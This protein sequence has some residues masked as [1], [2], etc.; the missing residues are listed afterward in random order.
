MIFTNGARCQSAKLIRFKSATQRFPTYFTLYTLYTL[1]AVVFDFVRPLLY[2]AKSNSEYG[3]LEFE[4][5]FV[6][7]RSSLPN[8]RKFT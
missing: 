7:N 2:L 8:V 3:E 1:W 6:I 5:Q 4:I